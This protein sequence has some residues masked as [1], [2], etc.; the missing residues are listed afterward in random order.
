MELKVAELLLDPMNPRTGASGSQRVAINGLI[1]EG[2]SQLLALAD[3]ILS[4]EILNPAESPIAVRE[5]GHYVVIEGN[6]RLACLKLLRNPDL[7]DDPKI[8]ARFRALATRGRGPDTIDAWVAED[9]ESAAHWIRLRHTGE[10]AG[11]G[12]RS[13]NT[14]QQVRFT[15]QKNTQAGRAMVFA[16]GVGAAFGSDR[17]VLDALRAAIDRS[18]TTVG[19]V[20]SDPD[21]RHAFGFDIRGDEL[22]FRHARRAT[23][24]ALLRLLR[25]LKAFPVGKF[26]S[27]EDRSDYVQEV[28]ADLPGADSLLPTPARPEKLPEDDEAPDASD[29]DSDPTS[30]EADQD[31]ET[32]SGGNDSGSGEDGSTVPARPTREDKV[33]YEGLRL[34]H[35]KV[36]SKKTLREAQTIKIDDAPH[37]CAVM[38][39]VVLELV[40]TEA[41]VRF[42]WFAESEHLDKKVVAAVK[43]LDPDYQSTRSAN[44]DLKNAYNASARDRG[45]VGIVDLHAAVHSI[46]RVAST[47][48]VRARSA[49]FMPLLVAIDSLLGQN[50]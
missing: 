2:T 8:A 50:P 43:Q 5:D 42:K 40:L 18:L 26:M 14:E 9:R 35:V 13:W 7:A 47:S 34:K 23:R 31:G 11:V 45:G 41:G 44:P 30:T 37:V 39:R 49:D 20:I 21:V 19:R 6:R 28:K 24:A 38:L 48:D 12:V 32:N 33:I 27:K 29:D 16:E 25:D 1:A 36:R 17:E 4:Q 15:R 10:N 22:I 3:D 46:E